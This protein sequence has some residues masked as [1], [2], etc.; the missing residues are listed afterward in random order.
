MAD[1]KHHYVKNRMTEILANLTHVR[2][3]P[4]WEFAD[5]LGCTKAMIMEIVARIELKHGLKIMTV[6]IPNGI[7]YMVN[8]SDMEQVY[9]AYEDESKR[10]VH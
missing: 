10:D 3:V 8:K 4:E 1:R 6:H 2:P 7:A 9:L 5:I